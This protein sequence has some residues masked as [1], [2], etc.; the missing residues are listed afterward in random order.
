MSPARLPAVVVE[1]DDGRAVVG[2]L[3]GGVAL[4]V[5]SGPS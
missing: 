5:A 2:D 1:A 3:L 4:E